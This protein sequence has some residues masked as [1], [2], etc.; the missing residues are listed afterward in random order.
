MSKKTKDE[1]ITKIDSLQIDDD[2]KLELMEDIS[3]SIEENGNSEVE[4]LKKENESLTKDVELWREK[5]KDRFMNK[6]EIKEIK[7]EK[8]EEPEEKEEKKYIDVKEI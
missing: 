4:K 1:L 8:F 5:Y 7:E 6:E 2:S 3:D